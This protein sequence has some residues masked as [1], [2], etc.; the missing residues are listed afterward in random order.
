MDPVE[1]VAGDGGDE[2]AAD[3]DA[4]AAADAVDDDVDDDDAVDCDGDTYANDLRVSPS[5]AVA[6][7]VLAVFVYAIVLV[8]TRRMSPPVSPPSP[9]P[10]PATAALAVVDPGAVTRRVLSHPCAAPESPRGIVVRQPSPRR[11]YADADAW[12]RFF[13]RTQRGV[14]PRAPRDAH[15]VATVASPCPDPTLPCTGAAES[16][17]PRGVPLAPIEC[18]QSA[19]DAS[20]MRRQLRRVTAFPRTAL[21][22]AGD[23]SSALDVYLALHSTET[24]I[25]G[26]D[27][28]TAWTVATAPVDAPPPACARNLTAHVDRLVHERADAARI[29]AVCGEI[30]AY[31]AV[32][33]FTL[34]SERGRV[35]CAATLDCDGGFAAFAL[36]AYSYALDVQ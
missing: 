20:A 3:D 31:A 8:T 4:A 15:R 16:V 12:T 5:S 33:A 29:A 7:L 28:V 34:A 19:S 22:S 35:A 9:P 10:P 25:V 21:G 26:R 18:T 11:R 1:A 36:A 23:D 14:L 24:L 32:R 13:V 30:G 2:N 27:L 6:W 17:V